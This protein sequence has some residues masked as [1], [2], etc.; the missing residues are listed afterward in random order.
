MSPILK[1]ISSLQTSPWNF[2]KLQN[3]P[4]FHLQLL[5]LF[6]LAAAVQSRRRRSG[7]PAR[8]RSVSRWRPRIELL[9]LHRPWLRAGASSPCHAAQGSP[10]GRHL[11]VAMASP[12]QRPPPSPSERSSTTKAPESYSVRS[13]AL[14]SPPHPRTRRRSTVNAD[15]LHPAVA[16]PFHSYSA[17]ADPST[18]SA[19]SSR[20]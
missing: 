20:S 11:A 5:P 3:D 8:P 4:F 1:V 15:E 7:G 6:F 18:S 13:F 10:R 2:Q 9:L 12:L 17:R 16:L 14:S 19:S